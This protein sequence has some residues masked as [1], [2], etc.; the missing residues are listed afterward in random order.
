MNVVLWVGEG[1]GALRASAASRQPTCTST[2]L[3]KS[4]GRELDLFGF[5]CQ[6]KL[7]VINVQVVNYRFSY[8]FLFFSV[9]KDEN[10]HLCIMQVVLW[11]LCTY[12]DFYFTLIDPT[13]MRLIWIHA[14]FP[15]K[16]MNL[17]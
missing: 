10:R 9:V 8:L 12:A 7:Y 3:M 2:H 11:P 16:Q 14:F 6:S 1:A 5:V 15:E 4:S 13:E 17:R